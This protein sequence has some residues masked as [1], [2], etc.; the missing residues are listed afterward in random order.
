ML[1]HKGTKITMF[2]GTSYKDESID[3]T[4]EKLFYVA[5][6][7]YGISAGS[8]SQQAFDGAT[9]QIDKATK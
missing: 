1:E 6:S 2:E 7:K 8:T 4:S 9:Q 3:M 5:K